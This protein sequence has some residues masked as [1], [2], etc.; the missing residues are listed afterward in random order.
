MRISEF[1]SF[2]YPWL[3][4]ALVGAILA[5]LDLG[6]RLGAAR[7]HTDEPAAAR[8]MSAVEGAVFALLGLLLAFTFASATSRFD[9]R[10]E[11][12]IQEANAIGTAYLRIDLFDEE[13]QRQ[14]RP[15]FRRYVELRLDTYKALVE[16]RQRYTAKLAETAALQQQIWRLAREAAAQA[17][18]PSVMALALP[19]INEMIDLTSTRL[20]AIRAHLPVVIYGLLVL[21][22][23]ASAIV[24]GRGMPGGR[25]PWLHMVLFTL[26]MAGTIY[27]ILDIEYPRRGLI[28]V[29]S[30][31]L[32]MI[33]LLDTMRR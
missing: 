5:C 29:D 21:L 4:L 1:L 20:A 19:P 11:L 9:Q 15:L 14:L 16:D 24:V 13:H 28:R 31:D 22:A 30:S 17:P 12:V 8:G 32:H 23:L 2:N 33:E 3:G 25:R 18:N 6:R 10:R 26:A 7:A 27:V